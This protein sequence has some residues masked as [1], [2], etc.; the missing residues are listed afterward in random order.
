MVDE[1]ACSSGSNKG[2]NSEVQSLSSFQSDS[3]DDNG[4]TQTSHSQQ[5]Q[6]RIHRIPRIH[7]ASV[8]GN[9]FTLVC[10]VPGFFHQQQPSKTQNLGMCRFNKPAQPHSYENVTTDQLLLFRVPFKP[11]AKW[12]EKLESTITKFCSKKKEKERGLDASTFRNHY[13]ANQLQYVIK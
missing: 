1:V 13:L 4:K 12:F 3:C 9:V 7:R 8:Y 6:F 5:K 2:S 10:L 11:T